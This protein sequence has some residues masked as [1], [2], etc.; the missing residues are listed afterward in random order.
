MTGG[1]LDKGTPFAEYGTYAEL[2]AKTLE[3]MGFDPKVLHAVPARAVRK[4][5]TYASAVALKTWLREH[6]T[7]ASRINILTVG[8]HARRTRLLFQQAFGS[9]VRIGIVSMDEETFDPKRWWRS[10]QGFRS[11]MDEA[12]AF[13]YARFL[14]GADSE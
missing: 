3:R 10:S 11:V 6:D 8:V 2:T 4:D 9:D 12:I 5:R 13:F 14:F 7:A 1:P